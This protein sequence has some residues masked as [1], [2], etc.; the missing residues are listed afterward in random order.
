MGMNSFFINKILKTVPIEI[1][2]ADRITEV[3]GT[4]I[5][6]LEVSAPILNYKRLWFQSADFSGRNNWVV[7]DEE[8]GV[9]SQNYSL[10]QV[11]G[12]DPIQKLAIAI[13]LDVQG[14]AFRLWLD[15]GQEQSSIEFNVVN[16]LHFFLTQVVADGLKGPYA[17]N[18][19]SYARTESFLL[20]NSMANSIRIGNEEA[21]TVLVDV[22]TTQLVVEEDSE[23]EN[24]LFE[25]SSVEPKNPVN[26]V[27]E[28][29]NYLSA[30]LRDFDMEF[31]DFLEEVENEA[32]VISLFTGPDGAS[33]N[34]ECLFIRNGLWWKA[35]AISTADKLIIL[36]ESETEFPASNFD[37]FSIFILVD[38]VKRL[39]SAL[40]SDGIE[41]FAPH[42]E[43]VLSR[44]TGIIS[45]LRNNSELYSEQNVEADAKLHSALI[46][47]SDDYRLSLNAALQLL[48]DEYYSEIQVD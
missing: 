38:L 34:V 20:L 8:F 16:T 26:P 29:M 14:Y 24:Q 30:D 44:L 18:V 27:S 39:V 21:P 25:N 47:I 41:I 36:K 7:Q 33:Q 42:R 2:C 40:Y 12:N 37:Q 19:I 4:K 11:S 43:S 46:A 10:P 32:V 48:P 3:N 5:K 6:G 15:G 45:A 28:L 13:L 31:L 35:S 22:D 9:F 17:E 23:S 1:F